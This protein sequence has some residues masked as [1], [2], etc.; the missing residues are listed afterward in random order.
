ML[1]LVKWEV[2][3]VEFDA[4]VV[5]ND[6]ERAIV[7]HIRYQEYAVHLQ[8][9]PAEDCPDEQ[10]IDACDA[11]SCHLLVTMNGNP[12][13]TI[14]NID[15][16]KGFLLEQGTFGGQPYTWPT[17]PSDHLPLDRSRTVEVS[18]FV[19]RS[20]T[21]PSG[22]RVLLSQLLLEANMRWSQTVGV[23]HWICAFNAGVCDSFRRQGWP[24]IDTIPGIHEYH[25]A[26][27]YVCMLQIPRRDL[28]P[29]V[30]T[31]PPMRRATIPPLS[32]RA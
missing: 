2:E 1:S 26:K 3:G 17:D 20:Q 30:R 13:G 9:V 21:L 28:F 16:Q 10:E 27:V 14:R 19:G 6:L 18:R 22:T 5:E 29:V 7:Y 25:G 4:G 8:Q 12:V 23:R 15:V 31:L 32:E 11:H 24:F